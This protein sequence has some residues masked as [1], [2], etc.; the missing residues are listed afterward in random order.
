MKKNEIGGICSMNGEGRDKK[1]LGYG[2]LVERE[3][4]GIEGSVGEQY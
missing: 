1:Y 4:F 2:I 3:Y